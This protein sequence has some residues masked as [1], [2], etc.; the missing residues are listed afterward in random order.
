MSPKR[1]T[2]HIVVSD[3]AGLP[4]SKGLMAS[5]LMA[6]GL[7]PFRAYEVAER[8]ESRLLSAERFEI[9]RAELVDLASE[10][11][12]EM[13]GQRYA[14]TYR[15]WQRVEELDLPFI[16]LIGGTTGT[17]KSTVATQLAARLGITRIISTD[18]IREAMRSLFSE[19]IMPALHTSSFEASEALRGPIPKTA[20]PVIIGFEQQVRAVSV[21]VEALIERSVLEGTDLIIEGAHLVPGFIESPDWSPPWEDKAV[22]VPIVIT[23]DDEDVHRSHFFLR[24]MEAGQRNVE[25][26]LSHFENIRKIQKFIRAQ[27]EQRD[28]PVIASYSLDVTLTAVIDHL[29]EQAVKRIGEAAEPGGKSKSQEKVKVKQEDR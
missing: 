11:V 12:F 9:T 15:N 22:V 16:V 23:V 28:V 17:G 19:R 25:R 4:F 21:A 2:Q 14:E 24:E 29:V 20:D 26:Y 5:S 8:I 13:V 27:A 1:H 3:R 6:T 7:A 18:A 10:T